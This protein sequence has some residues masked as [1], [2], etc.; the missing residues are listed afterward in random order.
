MAIDVSENMI[1]K[2]KEYVHNDN[3]TF[4]HGDFMDHDFK[5]KFDKI[6][7]VRVFEYIS[8]KKE[9]FRKTSTYNASPCCGVKLSGDDAF[10]KNHT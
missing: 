1:E 10:L 7:S 9:F 5:E 2:A 8:N 4:I 3:V 6:F